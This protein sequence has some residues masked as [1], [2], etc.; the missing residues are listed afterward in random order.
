[1][2]PLHD[3]A[4]SDGERLA[5]VLALVDA[6][7]GAL[8]SQLGDAVAHDATARAHRTL[9][10]KQRLKMRAG[11]VIIVINGVP[12]VEL[13]NH[14]DPSLPMNRRYRLGRGT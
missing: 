8:A 3:R 6:G 11:R 4:D 12:N 9:R 14:S 1:M 2:R 10:P 5:A 7:A 13:A